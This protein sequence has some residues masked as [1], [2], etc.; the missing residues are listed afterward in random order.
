[1][2]YKKK[3]IEVALPLDIINIAS[4]KDKRPESGV[5][6]PWIEKSFQPFHWK[7]KAKDGNDIDY[8][9][10][11]QCLQRAGIEIPAEVW[12]LVQHYPQSVSLI[13]I[14]ETGNPMELSGRKIVSWNISKKI[15]LFASKYRI[16]IV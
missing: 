12:N 15:E 2:T 11:S 7:L 14:D 13:L 6:H 16:R 9:V 4:E 1:M 10:S 5:Y 3:L 8:W